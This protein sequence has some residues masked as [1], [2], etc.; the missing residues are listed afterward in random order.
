MKVKLIRIEQ[1]KPN[2][3]IIEETINKE[4]EKIEKRNQ[5]IRD[6]KISVVRDA[7]PE[8]KTVKPYALTI[9]IVYE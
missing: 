1:E 9:M 8:Y 7:A 4:I 6:V 2:T 5:R 3:E